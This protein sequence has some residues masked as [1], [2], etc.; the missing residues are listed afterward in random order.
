[1]SNSEIIPGLLYQADADPAIFAEVL[2]ARFKHPVLIVD[3]YGILPPQPVPYA[4]AGSPIIY[5]SHP[6]TDGP[7]P[8]MDTFL[9]IEDFAWAHMQRGFPVVSL[10]GAGL[11]RS[12]LLSALLVRDTL[13]VSG[14]VAVEYVRTRR[15]SSLNNATFVAYIESLGVPT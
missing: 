5:L 8:Q 12:G 14:R 4:L 11:N 2:D 15:A 3:L 1:M 7:L 6:I 9:A 10:C 13:R